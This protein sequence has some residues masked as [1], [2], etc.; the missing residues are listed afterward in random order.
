MRILQLIILLY[1]L[2]SIYAYAEQSKQYNIYLIPSSNATSYINSFNTL[3]KKDNLFA[4]YNIKP[5]TKDHPVHLTLYL[6]SFQNKNL[7]QIKQSVKNIADTNKAFTIT[8]SDITVG[9]SGFVM[10]DLEHSKELQHLSNTA[11][12]DT[13]QYRDKEYPM[14]SWVKFYPNKQKSFEKYGSPNAFGNFD[15]HFSILAANLKDEKLRNSFVTDFTAA[16]KEFDAKHTK[17]KI[18]GIGF[19]EVDADG[20][21]TKV[22]QTNKFKNN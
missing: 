17:V 4:K 22:L 6:T 10:M 11:I 8:T 13:S 7:T 2:S 21:V 3:V 18:I 5:F 19:G 16:I 14:P 20:Q 1:L 9:K 12:S 15:P